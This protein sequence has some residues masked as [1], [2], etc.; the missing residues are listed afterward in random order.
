MEHANELLLRHSR[1]TD[2]ELVIRGQL[3]V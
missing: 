3:R 1:L 2:H